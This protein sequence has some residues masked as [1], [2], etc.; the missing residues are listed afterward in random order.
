MQSFRH[1]G[2]E[3]GEEG[4]VEEDQCGELE[5]VYRKLLVQQHLRF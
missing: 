1:E 4:P 5:E 2:G 3:Q